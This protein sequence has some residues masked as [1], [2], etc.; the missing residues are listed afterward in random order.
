MLHTPSQEGQ[1]LIWVLPF[2]NNCVSKNK[3][4]DNSDELGFEK[5]ILK[6]CSLREKNLLGPATKAADDPETGIVIKQKPA[7]FVI[8]DCATI[9]KRYMFIMCYGSLTDPIGQLKGKVSLED[10]ENFVARSRN[11]SNYE[12]R[13]LLNLIFADINSYIPGLRQEGAD[14]LD[15]NFDTIDEEN[16]YGDY[17]DLG[18]E[19]IKEMEKQQEIQKHKIDLNN[20]QAVVDKLAE[21]FVFDED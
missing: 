11:K 14:E 13:Q 12:T 5:A 2:I 10:V 1:T 6:V 3:K 15:I 8:K 16:V 4:D 18:N 7:F 17:E 21:V 19:R 9:A 20:D